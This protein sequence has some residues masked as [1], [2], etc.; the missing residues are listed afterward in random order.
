MSLSSSKVSILP[1]LVTSSC[2]LTETS[3]HIACVQLFFFI[4]YDVFFPFHKILILFH[5][6]LLAPPYDNH[7]SVFCI[8]KLTGFFVLF[9]FLRFYL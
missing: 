1:L 2:S 4:H 9:Y 5:P 3:K 7:Q 6:F 8:Y